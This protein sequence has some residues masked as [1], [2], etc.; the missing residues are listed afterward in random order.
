MKKKLNN[1]PIINE[2]KGNAAF[3][4]R[5]PRKGSSIRQ[6]DGRTPHTDSSSPHTDKR[7]SHTDGRLS[8][9]LDVTA[10]PDRP[11]QRTDSRAPQ[12]DGSTQHTDRHLSPDDEL[13]RELD[14]QKLQTIIQELSS[15]K[16]DSE[17]V[18]IRMSA[19]EKL[20]IE[21]FIFGHLRAKGLQ[22][23]Q[24]SISRIMRYAIRYFI[25]VHPQVFEESLKSALHKEAKLT[26]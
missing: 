14:M 11:T 4:K 16:V 22:G 26:V 1:P 9:K 13:T 5:D 7:M 19:V 18:S 15:I 23:K 25:K 21:D 3:F 2:L 17:R 8:N 24:V 20:E 12:T 10:Q 6:A